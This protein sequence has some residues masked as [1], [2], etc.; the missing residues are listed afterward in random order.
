MLWLYLGISKS[1]YTYR[2]MSVNW[3]EQKY[4]RIPDIGKVVKL[5]LIVLIPCSQPSSSACFEI[6]QNFQP[7]QVTAITETTYMYT[8][9]ARCQACY[10]LH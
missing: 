2:S 1:G 6:N 8:L 9:F 10:L 4:E 7:W 3:Q 5:Q